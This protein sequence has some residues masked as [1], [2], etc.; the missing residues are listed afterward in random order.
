[1]NENI[2]FFLNIFLIVCYK[3]AKDAHS[4]C[5]STRF[6]VPFYVNVT[7]ALRQTNP[8]T[9]AK[10]GIKKLGLFSVWEHGHFQQDTFVT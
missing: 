10:A 5:I 6:E 3:N 9:S 4:E 2:H 7:E 8:I 1:M